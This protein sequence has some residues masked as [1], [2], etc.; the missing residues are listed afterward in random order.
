[1]KIYEK[2]LNTN[3]K[4]IEL[5][6]NSRK[7]E[8]VSSFTN[9]GFVKELVNK[10]ATVVELVFIFIALL[11]IF[12][13]FSF[14]MSQND[15]ES[16]V[17]RRNTLISNEKI[18]RSNLKSFELE[19]FSFSGTL[20][21]E[22]NF[23]D[24]TNKHL[25]IKNSNLN[26][27]F[28]KGKIL[29]KP[30]Q[31]NVKFSGTKFNANQLDSL[32][33]PLLVPIQSSNAQ[34]KIPK[35]LKPISLEL[36]TN[37]KS[38]GMN[39]SSPILLRI[40]K[41]EKKLEVWKETN[42]GEFELLESFDICY[43]TGNLGPKTK[44]G[45]LQAPEGYYSVTPDQLNPNSSYHLSIF[46]GYPNEYDM[47]YNRTGGA[48]T[49]LGGCASLGSYAMTD[50]IIESIYAIAREA[51]NGG[52]KE[53]Q[54][55]AYPFHMTD[56]NLKLYHSHYHQKFWENLKEGYDLFKITK[57]P[58]KINVCGGKY[59][60]DAI[61]KNQDDKFNANFP[62]PSYTVVKPNNGSKISGSQ[63]NVFQKSVQ[64]IDGI[65]QDNTHPNIPKHMKPISS[66]L[67][68]EMKSKGMDENSP[69][70]IRIFKLEKELE[71]WKETK[72]GKYDLLETFQICKYSGDLGPKTEQG[73]LQ[74]PEGYYT[75][76]QNQMNPHSNYHLSIFIGYPNLYDKLKNR[77][78]GAITILGGCESIGSYAMTNPIIELIYAIAREAFTG[79]QSEFQIHAYPFHMTN[80]NLVSQYNKIHFKFWNNIKE[81][82]D[83][84][85]TTKKPLEIGVCD[86]MYVFNTTEPCPNNTISQN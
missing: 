27:A 60:F 79:G 16:F 28:L 55:H 75:V 10:C 2:K 41:M 33:A 22:P 81:G 53:F 69:I 30:L 86:E 65:Q 59:V 39:E 74:A 77:T 66:E 62:C 8:Q 56:E 31:S 51:F 37:M 83:I 19:N 23:T 76:F 3:F 47:S 48:I 5:F 52:Q 82:Y 32:K 57:K 54:I 26:N 43:F 11:S 1:M 45:D 7:L 9:S 64:L 21:T 24:L 44:Q 12:V 17:M 46:I 20:Q 40:F 78:G 80:D 71:I 61:P 25:S 35:H 85:N 67:M 42:S 14:A 34:V 58:L 73:D 68:S 50:P 63:L 4:F 18:A 6:P 72:S 36:R 49:I 15:S 29:E 38:K 84:F 13:S 70:L